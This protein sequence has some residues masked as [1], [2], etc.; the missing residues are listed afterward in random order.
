MNTAR[1]WDY[2]WYFGLV[3]FAATGLLWGHRVVQILSVEWQGVFSDAGLV[4]IYLSDAFF[5]V[6]LIGGIGT[7]V[8]RRAVQAIPIIAIT[9]FAILLMAGSSPFFISESNHIL[10]VHGIIR[11]IQGG[12]VVLF[13]VAMYCTR[14]PAIR[15]CSRIVVAAALIHVGVG[16]IQ[17]VSGASIGGALYYIGEPNLSLDFSGVAKV[18]VSDETILLRA[19]GLLPHPNILGGV[20]VCTLAILFVMYV[21]WGWARMLR[22]L[23]LVAIAIQSAGL[24]LTFS[25]SAW[26]S[27]AL[28]GVVS[29]SIWRRKLLFP[30]CAVICGIAVMMVYAPIRDAVTLRSGVSLTERYAEE[31]VQ[32]SKQAYEMWRRYPLF[33]IGA[34]QTVTESMRMFSD[35]KPW[36]HTYAH[37]VPLVILVEH[38]VVG[39]LGAFMILVGAIHGMWRTTTGRYAVILLAVT[40]LP[41]LLFDHYLWTQQ[42]GRILLWGIVGVMYAIRITNVR[43]EHV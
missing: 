28:G 17:V 11:L 25:R 13:V 10:A 23:L 39:M 36:Q 38:G 5:L 34:G 29:V 12:I 24:L 43:T 2:V 42:P 30:V 6:A 32:F 22:A 18:F 40:M 20:L 41:L 31:R 1:F 15:N 27:A 35:I 26:I 37:A 3:G 14:S 9:G 33:G 19:Y 7:G 16:I 4:R 21:R 8:L